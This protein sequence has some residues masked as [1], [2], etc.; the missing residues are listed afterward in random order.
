VSAETFT[1]DGD[2]MVR[3]FWWSSWSTERLEEW[4]EE[5]A[6][7]GWHLEKA[8]RLL[9]RCRFRRGRPK[10]VRYCVDFPA[11][12]SGDYYTLYSD[13]GWE[14]VA[15]STGWYIW[16]AE[17][18]GDRRPE[19]FN[20]VQP[21]IERNNRLLLICALGLMSQ[22]WIFLGPAREWFLS[23]TVGN[24]VLIPYVLVLF[25]LV[26]GAGALAAQTQRL[27]QRKP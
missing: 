18:T 14:L 9:L 20:D 2:T 12:V 23:T 13:A 5:Q 4:L 8:D 16:R 21:L 27:R 7:R 17:Y 6:S 10:K 25:I 26:A 24:I 3:W 15:T 1:R 11:E 22:L 19:L